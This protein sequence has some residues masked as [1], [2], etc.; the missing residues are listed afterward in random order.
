MLVVILFSACVALI[1]AVGSFF[2]GR[3]LVDTHYRSPKVVSQRLD[4][5]MGQ[6]ELYVQTNE[7]R[8]TDL[9]MVEAWNLQH[10]DVCMTI[11][12]A[13][14]TVLISDRY[15]T[16]RISVAGQLLEQAGLRSEILGTY[17]I[18]FADGI[19]L[20]SAY[21]YPQEQLYSAVNVIAIALA[22]GVFLLIVLLYVRHLTMLIRDLGKQVRL[23]S[24]GKLQSA[25]TPGSRDEI[26]DLAADVDTMRLSIIDKLQ[27]EEQAWQANSQLIAALSHDIRT[28]LTALMGYLDVLAD[29][30]LPEETRQEY[31]A[32][33][34]KQAQRLKDLTNELLGFFL[35]YGQSQPAQ[36]L[37]RFDAKM[38]LEQILGEQLAIFRSRG[39]DVRHVTAGD[40]SGCVTVDLSHLRRVFDNL[41]SNVGKYADI[42][43]SVTVLETVENGE[44]HVCISNFIP[45]AMPRVESTKIGLATCRKLME[46]MGGSFLQRKTGRQFTAEVVLPLEPAESGKNH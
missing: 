34:A 24:R 40:I 26:G 14:D 46:A 6:F 23:V 22:A 13:D 44:L 20:V 19:Y 5:E 21:E 30:Q 17:D 1:V 32:V 2:L 27:R 9:A 42:G 38:L 31:L 4:W 15:G 39:Y 28:P 3:Y 36:T 35:V 11:Y 12:G 45:S 29:E 7:I 8:S 43:R 10:P 33:C 25:I 18:T 16:S 37:E 41:F